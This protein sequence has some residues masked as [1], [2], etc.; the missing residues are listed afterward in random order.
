MTA[1]VT[2]TL[3]ISL[4]QGCIGSASCRDIVDA[5]TPV[6]KKSTTPLSLTIQIRRASLETLS[7]CEH[8][9]RSRAPIQ[10]VSDQANCCR[11]RS[12]ENGSID[13]VRIPSLQRP[14][15][16]PIPMPLT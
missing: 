16:C 2:T 6:L 11:L 15:T 14:E 8:F 5:I 3:R 4:V 1:T 10:Y 7:R 12:F 9:R 13:A